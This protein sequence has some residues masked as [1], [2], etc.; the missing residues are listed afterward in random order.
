MAGHQEIQEGLS[1]PSPSYGDGEFVRSGECGVGGGQDSTRH[2]I[3]SP[4]GSSSPFFSASHIVRRV[5]ASSGCRRVLGSAHNDPHTVC[6][7]CCDG[8]CDVNNRCRKC[9][10][11]SPRRVLNSRKY[12]QTLQK[13]RDYKAR[14]KASN[15]S[16][17]SQELFAKCSDSPVTHGFRIRQGFGT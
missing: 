5:C 1:S 15:P 12:Q 11:W 14:K 17:Q 2:A 9:A 10:E 8:F 6:I 16:G 3:G 13:R 7:V 4:L